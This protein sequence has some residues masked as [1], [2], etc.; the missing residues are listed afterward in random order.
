MAAFMG[1]ARGWKVLFVA[2]G[3]LQRAYGFSDVFPRYRLK[4]R[5]GKFRFLN[6][7]DLSVILLRRSAI[8]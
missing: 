3:E 5:S 4:H 7:A 8:T 6:R 2:L 1:T